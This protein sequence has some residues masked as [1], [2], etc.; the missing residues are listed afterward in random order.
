MSDSSLQVVNRYAVSL[1]DIAKET[2]DLDLMYE[3]AVVLREVFG[4]LFEGDALLVLSNEFLEHD[5]RMLVLQSVFDNMNNE[6]L[7]N[8]MQLIIA[9]NRIGLICRILDCF[10]SIIS[11]NGGNVRGIVYSAY[12]LG[13]DIEKI[14]S[15]LSALLNKT[16]ILESIIDSSLIGGFVIE[17]DNKRIDLSVVGRL[18]SIYNISK[19]V[20]VN[21]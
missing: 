1:Y 6:L 17:F 11:D 19:T 16:V 3:D 12:A 4:K 18:R 14:G 2:G 20:V 7:K 21:L 5:A 13:D 10:F 15:A 8:F 9:N